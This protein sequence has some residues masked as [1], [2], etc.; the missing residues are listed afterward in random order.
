MLPL[1][2]N[3]YYSKRVEAKS[4]IESDFAMSSANIVLNT[5]LFLGS[6]RTGRLGDRVTAWVKS[7]LA[8]RSTPLGDS[9]ITHSVRVVDPID[10]FGPDGAL[11][12]SGCE[13]RS[14]T[15]FG[16]DTNLSVATLELREIIKSADCFLIVS[17]EYNHTIPPALSSVMGHFG[18][19]NYKCKPAGIVTY[20]PGP[21]GGMRAAMAI[22]IMC[23]ELGCLPVSKLVGLPAVMDLFEE[24]GTPK[25]TAHR[26]LGQLP[27]L[28]DQ[29]EWMAVAMKTQR[30]KTGTF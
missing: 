12:H 16:P 2:T 23:H 18:G 5:V 20:S 21:F 11:A 3:M 1:K 28:L 17:P 9:T 7:T 10:V 15:F 26:M 4:K 14:P 22:Q 30:E 13:L 19:S 8:S 27:E 6:A 24:D 29:V 25:D